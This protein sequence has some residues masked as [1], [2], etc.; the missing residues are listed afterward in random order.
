MGRAP[1]PAT[2]T[3]FLTEPSPEVLAYFRNKGFVVGFDWRDVWPQEHAHA[4][5]V[6][7][8]MEMDVLRTIRAEVDRA[9]ALG[10]PFEQ[11]QAALTPRLMQLGWWGRQEVVDPATGLPVMAQLGSPARL[12]IIYEANIRSANAAGQWERIQR[13]K[14][15]LPFLIYQHTTSREPREEHWAWADQP[16]VLP[17]DDPWWDTHFPPNGWQCNCWVLQA[18]EDDAKAAGWTPE[19]KA[20][21]IELEP[22]L[23]RRTGDTQMIPKGID[24]GWQTNAGKTRASLLD[25]HLSNTLDG[26]DPA[27][28]ATTLKDITSSWLYR[29]IADG[30]ITAR[31]NA[32]ELG[33]VVH[34]RPRPQLLDV[35]VPTGH[36][37]EAVQKAQ[38]WASGVVWLDPTGAA[39][40]RTTARQTAVDWSLLPRILDDGA[41]VRHRLDGNRLTAFREIDGQWY[42]VEAALRDRT[43]DGGILIGGP[44][45]RLEVFE[46]VDAK[47]VARELGVAERQGRLLRN[48][49]GEMVAKTLPAVPALPARTPPEPAPKAPEMSPPKPFSPESEY[50]SRAIREMVAA[51]A[52]DVPKMPRFGT[53]HGGL[54]SKQDRT[55]KVGVLPKP[56]AKLQG[57]KSGD[58]FVDPQIASRLLEAAG[59]GGL[60]WAKLAQILD[61]GAVVQHGITTQWLTIYR[62]IDGVLHKVEVMAREL[63]AEGDRIKGGPRLRIES[64]S[65]IPADAKWAAHDLNY[66]LD[67]ARRDGRLL[68]PG[69]PT[70]AGNRKGA[71]K[72]RR[73]GV[74]SAF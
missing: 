36:L 25:A 18:D 45:V 38:G 19:T 20:P 43:V 56:I 27:I 22:W 10:L 21:A 74:K 14:D 1:Q 33:D 17:V 46:R 9:I 23:N 16:V 8:A 62:E 73:K 37:S 15:I 71:A 67:N 52:A 65:R 6:A 5:T 12:R 44:R 68:S 72:R 24:A 4:F 2:T 53:W 61:G 41:L 32:P 47:V 35:A 30:K 50:L 42:R 63:T 57:L 11:F 69:K 60:D 31:P 66:D 3:Q 58:V 70:K 26:A 51:D 34:G 64:W 48:Q 13:S 29:G 49:A 28:R 39:M 40:V 59:T 7:K 54:P 55:V